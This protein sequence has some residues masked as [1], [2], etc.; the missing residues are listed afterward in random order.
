M[1][2]LSEKL[3]G[4]NIVFNAHHD[5]FPSNCFR[6]VITGVEKAPY[7]DTE[8]KYTV[9][10]ETGITDFRACKVVVTNLVKTGEHDSGSHLWSKSTTYIKVS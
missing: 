7:S 5:A 6:G 9:E 2:K 8:V 3:I 4:M 10:T 1:S